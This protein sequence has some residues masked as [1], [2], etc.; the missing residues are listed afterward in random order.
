MLKEG[1][2]NRAG[3]EVWLSQVEE[4]KRQAS[5]ASRKALERPECL[6]PVAGQTPTVGH[7]VRAAIRGRRTAEAGFYVGDPDHQPTSLALTMETV[8]GGH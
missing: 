6:P 2:T 4:R 7:W 5:E 8:G 1:N 3:R